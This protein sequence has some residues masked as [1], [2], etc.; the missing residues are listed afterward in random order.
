MIEKN[1]RFFKS[2]DTITNSVQFSLFLPSNA[3]QSLSK[4]A[5]KRH[6][7]HRVI[8]YLIKTKICDSVVLPGALLKITT[9]QSVRKPHLSRRTKERRDAKDFIYVHKS[10][11]AKPASSTE[12][13]RRCRLRNGSTENFLLIVLPPLYPIPNYT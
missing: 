9:S 1:L 5:A 7:G 13:S 6:S 3:M 10:G 2:N 12:R 8:C 11:G 4:E